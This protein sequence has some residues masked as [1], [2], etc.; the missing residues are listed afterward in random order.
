RTRVESRCALRRADLRYPARRT[1]VRTRVRC[2][3]VRCLRAPQLEKSFRQSIEERILTD[4]RSGSRRFLPLIVLERDSI[5]QP[6]QALIVGELIGH[7][8]PSAQRF[9]NPA[10]KALRLLQALRVLRCPDPHD[11][12]HLR[13]G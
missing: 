11:A 7:F 10:L 2:L 8:L 5:D 3:L 4:G 6:A 13:A 9:V 1:A 12:A